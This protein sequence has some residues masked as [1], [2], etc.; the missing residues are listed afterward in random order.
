VAFALTCTRIVT[1]AGELL[2]ALTVQVT[3][4]PLVVQ[5]PLLALASMIVSA[6]LIVSCMVMVR[7]ALLFVN[8]EIE[9]LNCWPITA[10]ASEATLAIASGG[11]F[12]DK[13][14]DGPTCVLVGPTVLVAPVVGD[15]PVVDVG[16]VVL[17]G[18]VVF[19]A[20]TEVLVALTEVF[21]ALTEVLVALTEV[22]V[23]LTE[24]LVGPGTLVAPGSVWVTR[25][26]SSAAGTLV[27]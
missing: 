6:E 21:V 12:C 5:V 24:V 22:F 13:V 4:L 11:S 10:S 3:S 8:T 27:G 15:A 2:R 19:V 14:G 25:C 16:P 20:L 7:C 17:V 1:V 18:P 9:K 23:A 26:C